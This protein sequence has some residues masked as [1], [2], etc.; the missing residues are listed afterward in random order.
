MSRSHHGGQKVVQSRT[1]S[2]GISLSRTQI[3][4]TATPRE[5]GSSSYSSPPCVDISATSASM[6]V[7]TSTIVASLRVRVRVRVYPKE[8][9]WVLWHPSAWHSTAHSTSILTYAVPFLSR[10]V[11]RFDWLQFYDPD[12]D[13]CDTLTAAIVS[14]CIRNF[15]AVRGISVAWQEG[16]ALVLLE[17]VPRTLGAINLSFCSSVNDSTLGVIATTW[18]NLE[19][20]HLEGCSSVGDAGVMALCAGCPG[21]VELTLDDTDVT[22][23]GVAA[24]AARCPKL[25]SLR[26]A[27][28]TRVTDAALHALGDGAASLK[29][30]ALRYTSAITDVGV[31]R[32]AERCHQ[33]QSL[34]LEGSEQIGHRS[35]MAVV[36]H[37]RHIQLLNLFGCH[38][39]PPSALGNVRT[40]LKNTTLIE[41]T[42]QQD[43]ERTVFAAM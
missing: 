39:V 35:A 18:P 25:H 13:C 26:L 22:D 31:V 38:R 8:V 16:P 41:P 42:S 9:E 3:P 2:L 14:R 27:N 37:C 23:V 11:V 12:Q 6:V 32:I 29:L 24:I 34:D 28:S 10:G 33:L 7:H 15:N 4:T 20:V 5:I 40:A 21:I 43:A 1:L 17:M 30:L 36:Q 19:I